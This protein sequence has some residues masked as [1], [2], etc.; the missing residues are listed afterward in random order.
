MNRADIMMQ[1]KARSDSVTHQT[2][3]VALIPA[4]GSASRLP[5]ISGSKEMLEVAESPTSARCPVLQHLL[6]RLAESGLHQIV[7]ITSPDKLDILNYLGRAGAEPPNVTVELIINSPSVIHTLSSV[8]GRFGNDS[9]L[10]ALP[11]VLFRPGHAITDM[12]NAWPLCQADLLL[13]LFPTERPEKSDIVDTDAVGGVVRIRVKESAAPNGYAWIMALWTPT[14]THFLTKW[15]RNMP[16]KN[17]DPQLGDVFN[18][19]ITAGLTIDTIKFPTGR[20]LDIGTPDDLHRLQ[21][22]GLDDSGNEPVAH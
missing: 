9:I 22:Q 19:A 7:L 16:P 10:M 14:F 11:D 12:Q 5:G 13:G 20:F 2:K 4:A 6:I 18:A 15:L 3:P 21:T 1:A 17:S 8:A